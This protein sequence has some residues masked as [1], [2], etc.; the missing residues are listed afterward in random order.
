MIDE[1]TKELLIAELK[2]DSCGVFEPIVRTTILH[3]NADDIVSQSIVFNAPH[4]LNK[5]LPYTNYATEKY[6]QALHSAVIYDNVPCVEVLW[7]RADPSF[8]QQYNLLK[9]SMLHKKVNMAHYLLDK[10]VDPTDKD[11][12]L[13]ALCVC[14]RYE[15]LVEVLLKK[16]DHKIALDCLHTEYMHCYDSWQWFDDMMNAREQKRVLEDSVCQNSV[17]P[18]FRKI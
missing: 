12:T 14:Q 2:R 4:V 16:C 11:Q 10:G 9:Q 7:E 3:G 1:K 18:S 8:Q 13:L 17:K 6:H 15:T 5:V